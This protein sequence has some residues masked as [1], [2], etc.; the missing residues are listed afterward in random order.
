[1]T[2]DPRTAGEIVDACAAAIVVLGVGLAATRSIGRSIWLVAIQSV[3]TGVAALAVG[4][5]TGAGH[6]LVGGLLV[7]GVKGVV[8]PLVLGSIL[9]RS[10]VRRANGIPCSGRAPPWWRRSR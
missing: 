7:I 3:L 4:L 6:L 9:R 2:I 8:V 5:G 1:M 10:P